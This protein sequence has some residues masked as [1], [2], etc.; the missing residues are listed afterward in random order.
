MTETVGIRAARGAFQAL[1]ARVEAGEEIVIAR[2]GKP[3]AMLVPIARPQRKRR[4][5]ALRGKVSVGPEFFDNLPEDEIKG[6]D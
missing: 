3:V 1:I 4:F 5:G 2:R 6:W